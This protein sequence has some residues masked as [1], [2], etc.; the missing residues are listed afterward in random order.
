MAVEEGDPRDTFYSPKF[1][2]ALWIGPQPVSYNNLHQLLGT[3]KDCSNFFPI[4][5]VID[6]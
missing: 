4:F 5:V 3:T 6:L 2:S 1:C